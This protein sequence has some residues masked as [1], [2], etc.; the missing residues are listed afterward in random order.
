MIEKQ[1]LIF[2]S[3]RS[4]ADLLNYNCISN[5]THNIESSS[6]KMVGVLKLSHINDREIINSSSSIFLNAEKSSSKTECLSARKSEGLAKLTPISNTHISSSKHEIPISTKD[7]LS[8]PKK[9]SVSLSPIQCSKSGSNDNDF[10]DDLNL[11]FPTL[12]VTPRLLP[13]T[14]A[15]STNKVESSQEFTARRSDVIPK[16]K[17]TPRISETNMN[18]SEHFLTNQGL[19]NKSTTTS[20]TTLAPLPSRPT[21]CSTSTGPNI[22]DSPRLVSSRVVPLPLPLPNQQILSSM[23]AIESASHALNT[24]SM[25][26]GRMN[27]LPPVSTKNTPRNIIH[28]KDVDELL[29]EPHSARRLPTLPTASVPRVSATVGPAS[30]TQLKPIILDHGLK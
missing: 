4:V 16:L 26:T 28:E 21:P 27:N 23:S 24:E 19:P 25:N 22:N 30:S 17:L 2:Q 6:N 9:D 7:F 18:P 20:T 5:K 13:V 14:S 15:T 11:K 29:N 10:S 3:P 8:D 12:T 1:E